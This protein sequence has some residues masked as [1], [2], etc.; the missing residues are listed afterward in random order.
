MCVPRSRKD[1]AISALASRHT[2]FF[3]RL[4]KLPHFFLIFAINDSASLRRYRIPTPVVWRRIRLCGGNA[5][6]LPF[7]QGLACGLLIHGSSMLIVAEFKLTTLES[8]F[9]K[10]PREHIAQ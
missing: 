9:R 4:R 5:E 7:F 8:N 2:L 1:G 6:E 10:T 3:A